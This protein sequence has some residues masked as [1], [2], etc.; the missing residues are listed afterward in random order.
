MF[1]FQVIA[2]ISMRPKEMKDITK[3]SKFK[4]Y[5]ETNFTI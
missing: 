2:L 5:D 3:S 4:T 1:N